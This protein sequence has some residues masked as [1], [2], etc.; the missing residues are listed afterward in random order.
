LRS[1][2]YN[3][4]SNA[5]KFKSTKPP[6]INIH[7]KKEGGNIILS[8]EDNGIGMQKE[9]AEKI[10]EIYGRINHDIEGNGIG[11]YLAKKIVDAEG[12]N[13]VVESEP[14]KG[15]KFSIHLKA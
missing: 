5:I 3:L 2:L 1:I 7:T 12:G 9:D 14:E 15:S 6:V 13:I 4:I 8:A 11:L 10:F